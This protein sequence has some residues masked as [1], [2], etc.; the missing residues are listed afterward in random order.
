MRKILRHFFSNYDQLETLLGE[1]KNVRQGNKSDNYQNEI[2]AF[3][4]SK[5]ELKGVLKYEPDPY[6]ESCFNDVVFSVVD[7][8]TNADYKLN[9][10]RL[11]FEELTNKYEIKCLVFFSDNNRLVFEAT[12]DSTIIEVGSKKNSDINLISFS[13]EDYRYKIRNKNLNYFNSEISKLYNESIKTVD[14]VFNFMNILLHKENNTEE[15]QIQQLL[16]DFDLSQCEFSGRLQSLSEV[17]NF[18][19]STKATNN[20]KSQI[21]W[22]FRR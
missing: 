13:I 2:E 9:E 10:I 14:D 5:D 7:F 11:S 16:Y 15:R 18:K 8:S 21:E 22:N 6:W 1:L 3:I 4:N 19:T 17:F 12:R 20:Y